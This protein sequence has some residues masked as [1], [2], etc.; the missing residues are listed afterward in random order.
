MTHMD[1]GRRIEIGDGARHAQHA[2]IAP[3]GEPQTLR[4]GRQHDPRARRQS[5]MA[6]EPASRDAPI[7]DI[8]FHCKVTLALYCARRLDPGANIRGTLP[9]VCVVELSNWYSRH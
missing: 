3:G 4:C 1:L 7:P 9:S 8:A 6:I 5:A 2:V